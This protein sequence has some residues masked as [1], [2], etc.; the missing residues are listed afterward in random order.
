MEKKKW[1]IQRRHLFLESTNSALALIYVNNNSPFYSQKPLD[2]PA[3]L[4][5]ALHC[6]S[7]HILGSEAH[8]SDFQCAS[9]QNN[10]ESTKSTNNL[11]DSVIALP[12]VDKLLIPWGPKHLCWPGFG[13]CGYFLRLRMQGQSTYSSPHDCVTVIT[14]V[15]IFRHP[16]SDVAGMHKIKVNNWETLKYSAC[17]CRSSQDLIHSWNCLM[18]LNVQKQI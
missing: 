2:I 11:S 6:F 10:H 1:K 15:T 12:S 18:H 5:L 4:L 14:D 7:L 9:E 3:V 13:S 17:V 16:S 8:A